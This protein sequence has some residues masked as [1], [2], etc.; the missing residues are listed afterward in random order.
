MIGDDFL[1]NYNEDDDILGE[2]LIEEDTDLTLVMFP[3]F[4]FNLEEELEK[5][6]RALKR[7][8]NKEQLMNVLRHFYNHISTTVLLQYEIRHLQER[9]KDL[10]VAVKLFQQQF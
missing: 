5:Y 7:C 6:Y 3:N 4:E 2:F 8:R 10:E 1:E 9:A